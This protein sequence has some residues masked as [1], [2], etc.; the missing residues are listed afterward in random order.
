MNIRAGFGAE[1]EACPAD[2]EPYCLTLVADQILAEQ[3]DGVTLLEV[4][5][6]DCVDCLNPTENTDLSDT[7]TVDDGT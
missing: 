3:V 2:G 7:C 4:G 6:G 1:C 5:Q